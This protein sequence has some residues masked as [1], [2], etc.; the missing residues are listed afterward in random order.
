M[1]TKLSAV[2]AEVTPL[3]TGLEDQGG[4]ARAVAKCLANT[5]VLLLKTQAY[6]WN[7]AGPMFFAIHNLTEKQYEDLF[8]AEDVIA[9][10]IRALGYPAPLS[11]KEM[12][13]QADIS[14]CTRLPAADE[15][16]SDL[17]SDH[18]TVSRQFREAIRLAEAAE[19]FVTADMLTARIQFHEKVI[20][21]LRALNR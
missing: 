10:R 20:W 3:K 14:E 18:E 7:V 15:M 2:K 13:A 12:I 11:G 21:M 5:H 9:E 6:H 17:I 19:D 4:L 16:L 8:A 1:R